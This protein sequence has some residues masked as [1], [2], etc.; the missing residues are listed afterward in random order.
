MTEDMHRTNLYLYKAD[1]EFLEAHY[2]YGWTGHIRELVHEAVLS[3]QRQQAFI[4]ASVES[5]NDLFAEL[6]FKPSPPGDL[7]KLIAEQDDV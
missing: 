3:V 5:D 4:S 1:C 7:T 6:Q 2:G